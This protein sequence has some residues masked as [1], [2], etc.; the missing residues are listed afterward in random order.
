MATGWVGKSAAP[1]ADAAQRTA[2]AAAGIVLIPVLPIPLPCPIGNA[3]RLPRDPARI[4]NRGRRHSSEA[5]IEN[6][7]TGCREYYS[8]FQ[9]PLR[10]GRPFRYIPLNITMTKIPR[11]IKLLLYIR[12][13]KPAVR[14]AIRENRFCRF[15]IEATRCPMSIP[16]GSTREGERPCRTLHGCHAPLPRPSTPRVRK[17]QPAAWRQAPRARQRPSTR[18]PGRTGREKNVAWAQSAPKGHRR[19]DAA[20]LQHLMVEELR[21][22]AARRGHPGDPEFKSRWGSRATASP[23]S[24]YRPTRSVRPVPKS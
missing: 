9:K 24:G 14:H 11:Q 21:R 15:R 8:P 3:S 10:A 23:R 17:R 7:Q 22:A 19:A 5:K 16:A 1:A 18:A 20:P 2:T 13:M 12:R 6:T 4:A